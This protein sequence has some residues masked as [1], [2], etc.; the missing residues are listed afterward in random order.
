M[1]CKGCGKD[2]SEVKKFHPRLQVCTCCYQR[3]WRKGEHIVKQHRPQSVDPVDWYTR[4][5]RCTLDIETG[6]WLS[7]APKNKDGYPWV[8][9][10]GKTRYLGHLILEKKLGR[11]LKEGM[12]EIMRHTCHVRHCVNPAHL[13][14]GSPQDNMNDKVEAGRQSRGENHGM[15]KIN[16]HQVRFILKYNQVHGDCPMYTYAELAKMFMLTKEY[17]G[18]VAR[19]EVWRHIA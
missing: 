19:R 4:D 7:H 18:E 2:S 15:T 3:Q 14:V 13:L 1:K 9:V 17:I 5:E 12:N 10:N 8:R 11:R 16:E 6:C